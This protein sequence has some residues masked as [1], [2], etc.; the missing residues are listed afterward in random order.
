VQQ[1]AQWIHA[2]RFTLKQKTESRSGVVAG[3][4]FFICPTVLASKFRHG[5]ESY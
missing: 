4:G 5:Y 1:H 3:S 2:W